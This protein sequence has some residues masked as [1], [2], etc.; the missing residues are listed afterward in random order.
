[1]LALLAALNDSANDTAAQWIWALAI[2][3]FV[4]AV[5]LYLVK[6]K[7]PAWAPL[8]VVLG[9]IGVVLGLIFAS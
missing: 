4:V 5:V 9:L 3:L 2:V 6:P 1:M 7:G 8:F